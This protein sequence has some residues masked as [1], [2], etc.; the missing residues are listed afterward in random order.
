MAKDQVALLI[1]FGSLLIASLSLGWNI[2]RDVILKAKVLVSCSIVFIIHESMPERPEY[3]RIEA[4]NFGPG[5][6]NVSTLCVKQAPLWRRLL[7]KTKWAVI[8]HDWTNPMSAKL[9]VKIEVGDQIKLLLPYDK[10]C[11]LKEPFTHVGISDYYGRIHWAPTY[12]LRKA[13]KDWRKKFGDEAQ[14]GV[15]ADSARAA[16]SLRG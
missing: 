5:P 12:Q 1:S 10:N 3:V 14:Q 7:R 4:T 2:F 13:R 11:F 15:A 16:R 6:V 9:P 8:T